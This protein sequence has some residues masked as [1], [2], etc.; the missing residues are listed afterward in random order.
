MSF[1]SIRRSVNTRNL[2]Y[3]EFRSLVRKNVYI[4]IFQRSHKKSGTFKNF[5]PPDRGA[6]ISYVASSPLMPPQH[7]RFS[8]R[9]LGGI[10]RRPAATR[11]LLAELYK[12]ISGRESRHTDDSPIVVPPSPSLLYPSVALSTP[13]S[14]AL[15][16]YR[17]ERFQGLGCC[18]ERWKDKD[19]KCV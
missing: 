17:L 7:R 2:F 4:N 11:P 16:L 3:R 8:E 12:S 6:Y 19:G 14:S 13:L 1:E 15:K 10:G 5:I 9:N 18:D